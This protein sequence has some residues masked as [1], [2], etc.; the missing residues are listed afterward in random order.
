[1][2]RT[3]EWFFGRGLSMSCGLTWNVTPQL[4]AQ[5]REDQ[6]TQIKRAI[7]QEMSAPNV[8]TQDIRIFLDILAT[9]T[10]NGWRHRFHTTNWDFLLQREVDQ[11]LPIGSVLPRWMASSQVFHHNGIAENIADNRNRSAFILESDPH[12]ARTPSLESDKAFTQ[13]VWSRLFVIVGMSFECTADR[14]LFNALGRVQDELPVGEASWIIVN[15]N[16]EILR[17]TSLKILD[18]LPDSMIYTRE[19]TF[20]SWLKQQLPELVNLGVLI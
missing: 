9:K 4:N 10:A 14:F 11:R 15:P 12:T 20:R 16:Q 2:M 18:E 13:L 7:A 3:V 6:V 19:S 8:N 17:S 1:M 5:S